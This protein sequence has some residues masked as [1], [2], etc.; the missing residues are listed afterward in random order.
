MVTVNYNADVLAQRVL[1]QYFSDY[2]LELHNALVSMH[3]LKELINKERSEP[4]EKL[5]KSNLHT[6]LKSTDNMRRLDRE[7]KNLIYEWWV[8]ILTDSLSG[9]DL[10]RKYKKVHQTELEEIENF[11]KENGL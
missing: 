4:E 7:P 8:S 10:W 9:E 1:K 5:Y 3:K 2:D 11:R 6:F